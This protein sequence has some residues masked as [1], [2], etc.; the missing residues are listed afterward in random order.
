M[1]RFRRLPAR[2]AIPSRP[3]LRPS[4]LRGRCVC[5][6]QIGVGEPIS[7]DKLTRTLLC[8]PCYRLNAELAQQGLTRVLDISVG[9]RKIDRIK[10]IHMLP[11]D[12]SA[13]LR[14]ELDSLMNDLKEDHISDRIV[15][16]FLFDKARCR[17]SGR[18]LFPF[19]SKRSNTC[20]Q[21]A[22]HIEAGKV[23]LWDPPTKRIWCADCMLRSLG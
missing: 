7:Y 18:K 3:G 21:C 20:V 5:G 1:P 2:N 12:K 10:E 14:A 16:K 19:E 22:G 17:T 15:Q 9:Q 11:G 6:S 4:Q 8:A 23:V 13:S